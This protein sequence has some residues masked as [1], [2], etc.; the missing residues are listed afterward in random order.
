MR[1]ERP[2][3]TE[4]K[5]EN[6]RWEVR[7]RLGKE[8]VYDRVANLPLDKVP[9]ADRRFVVRVTPLTTDV[10]D[11]KT[12]QFT[13]N[14][15]GGSFTPLVKRQYLDGNFSRGPQRVVLLG[16]P[17]IELNRID[18]PGEYAD[19]PRCDLFYEEVPNLSNYG[20]T[21]ATAG[22]PFSFDQF[23]G[24]ELIIEDYQ[25][26]LVPVGRYTMVLWEPSYQLEQNEVT[27]RHNDKSSFKVSMIR[28]TAKIHLGATGARPASNALLL[29][30][31]TKHRIQVPLDFSKL[32]EIPGIPVDQYTASTDIS[33]LEYWNHGVQISATNLNPPFYDTAS[34]KNEPRLLQAAPRQDATAT[35]FVGVKTRFGLAG[36]L[37]VLSRKPDSL[38][39][40]LYIEQDIGKILNLLLYGVETRPGDEED[41]PSLEEAF[42]QAGRDPLAKTMIEVEIPGG[43]SKKASTKVRV[44]A[45]PEEMR[46]DRRTSRQPEVDPQQE[47]DK[48]AEQ[49]E[50]ASEPK[51]DK[52]REDKPAA[53]KPSAFPKDPDTLRKLLAERLEVIDLLVL[54]PVDMVQ[55]RQS[56]EV[57]GIIARWVDAGGSLFAFVSS[58]GDYRDTVGAP[59]AIETMS[60]KTKRFDLSPGKVPGIVQVSKKKVKSKGRRQLPELTDLDRA[61][62]VLAYTRDGKGPRII[63]RGTRGE[64]GYVVLWFDDPE[65]FRGR[66][67]G[68]RPEVEQTRA[69]I[70]EHVFKWSRDLMRTRFGGRV[71]VSRA[72]SPGQ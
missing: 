14:K 62:R 3:Y 8:V 5:L 26:E 63:E 52:D 17:K 50:P 9:L 19:D 29:G 35:P 7:N 12:L 13:F 53:P 10:L 15:E 41:R 65:A 23:T 46:R 28:E 47:S 44:P 70:E 72:T 1:I 71:A 54:D 34:E 18:G 55:I 20:R 67:G 68:T 11:I 56:P 32:K 31:E 30:E 38:A 57:A 58:P 21:Y 16:G 39:A 60:K 48:T 27:V 36:R 49:E 33:G 64:G 42:A 59:L 37:R 4:I 69:N 40:D 66:F 45:A 6:A 2:G 25:G 43:P 22:Q 24:G 61:W 51:P